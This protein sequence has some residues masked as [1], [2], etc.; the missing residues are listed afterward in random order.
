MRQF[1]ICLFWRKRM[2]TIYYGMM[3]STIYYFGGWELC[4]QVATNQRREEVHPTT[5]GLQKGSK[6]R[7][8]PVWRA[9]VVGG[10]QVDMV[11]VKVYWDLLDVEV[12]LL[13]VDTAVMMLQS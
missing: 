9:D 11:T 13:L 2:H 10:L 3:L 6:A 4:N 1:S 7:G 8:N 5:Q 12:E